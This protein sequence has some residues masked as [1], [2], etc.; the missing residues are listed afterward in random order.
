MKKSLLF[1]LCLGIMTFLFSSNGLTFDTIKYE[2]DSELTI[3]GFLRNNLGMFTEKQEN[4]KNGNQLATDRTWL[5]VYGDYKM[6][7]QFRFWTAIQGVYEPWYKVE[8]GANVPEHG[9]TQIH[10]QSGW[11]TYSEYNDINDVLREAYF[12]YTPSKGN[13][14]KVGRQIAIWGEA[15]T[16]RVGDVIHPDDARF[17]LAFANLEDTRIPQYMVRGIHDVPIGSSSFEWIVN[18]LLL[19]SQYSVTRLP[20]PASLDG[21]VPQRFGPASDPRNAFGIALPGSPISNSFVNIPGVGP[22]PLK[23][24]PNVKTEYPNGFSDTRYGFRTNTTAGGYN[25]GLSYWHTQAYIPL[26][27]V[28]AQHGVAIPAGVLGPGFPPV[29]VP[30]QD[31]TNVFPT[32]DLIGFYMNKQL[33]WPGV[34]R[35]EA[36][37]APNMPFNTF[38]IGPG[39]SGIVRRDNVKYM[40]AYDLTGYIMPRWHPTDAINI[41]LEHIGEW[42]PNSRD[43]QFLAPVYATKYPNYHAQFNARIWTTWLYNKIETAIVAGYDTWGDSGLFMPSVKYTPAWFNEKFSVELKYIGIYGKNSYE[44]LGIF[45]NKDMVLLTTQFNF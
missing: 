14:I 27:Q 26:V 34:V 6:S 22:F 25:F 16:T 17:S 45:R 38:N 21:G 39:E 18:P 41:T 4:T 9:G 23:G 33:P 19:Q 2:N 28:G 24:V 1:V 35:A 32:Y 15:L 11:K 10:N 7:D 37:Y 36:E 20:L 30:Y 12:Q 29:N 13:T 43:L 3:Y 5:R 40:V 44:G 42:T 8:Q 31:Y